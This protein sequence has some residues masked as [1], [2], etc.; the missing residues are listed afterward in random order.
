MNSFTNNCLIWT[1]VQ[2]ETWWSLTLYTHACVCSIFANVAHIIHIHWCIPMG[3]RHNDP[4]VESHMWPQPKWCQGSSRDHWPLVSFLKKRSLYPHA[5]VYIYGSWTQKC[6]SMMGIRQWSL[7]RF[8]L[9]TSK[10]LGVKGHLRSLTF[11]VFC[12]LSTKDIDVFAWD[13]YG[14]NYTRVESHIWSKEFKGHLGVI[15]QL[16]AK[17]GRLVVREPPLFLRRC[18]FLSFQA[19]RETSGLWEMDDSRRSNMAETIWNLLLCCFLRVG[20]CNTKIVRCNFFSN[21]K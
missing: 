9:V 16:I 13:L 18:C 12:W 20:I 1:L 6:I 17:S 8:A 10:E 14:Y 4:W 3:L 7:G 19:V 5:S 15:Y 21:V 2:A 11:W